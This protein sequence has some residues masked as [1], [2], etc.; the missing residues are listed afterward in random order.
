[1][2]SVM[3]DDECQ[4]QGQFLSAISWSYAHTECAILCGGQGRRLGGI[5]KSSITWG[6]TTFL[7]RLTRLG[8]RVSPHVMWVRPHNMQSPEH[9]WLTNTSHT[10]SD[11]SSSSPIRVVHDLVGVGGV[12]GAIGAAL[13][14]ATREWMWVF[15]CDLPLLQPHHLIGL[16][17][18]AQETTAN[19][20]CVAYVDTQVGQVQPL[21][22][23]WRSDQ[24]HLLIDTLGR[25]RGGLSAYARR[26]GDLVQV[27]VD[28][29]GPQQESPFFNVNHPEDLVRLCALKD[30]E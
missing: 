18:R 8:L 17:Q 11:I 9:G 7:Q 1:M 20:R 28:E 23:L 21:C 19:A 16:A 6:E 4:L 29:S 27:A 12:L 24:V 25:E 2:A 10:Q 26:Y 3:M 30:I 13:H 14:A 22:A 15:A 5:D